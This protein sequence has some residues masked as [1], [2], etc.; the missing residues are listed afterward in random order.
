MIGLVAFLKAAGVEVEADS[1][2]IHL[3]SWTGRHDPLD[4]YYA[5][6][7][8]KW[9][10]DQKHRNFKGAQIIGL[11]AMRSGDWL[12]AGVYRV[13]GCKPLANGRFRYATSLLNGQEGLIGRII[14]HH[15]RSGRQPYIWF[16]P[17]ITTL[18]IAELRREKL[19]IGE[20]PGYNAV[21]LSHSNLKII[22]EQRIASWHGALANIAGV[23]LITDTTTGK[24]YVGKASGGEGIWQRWCSYAK[25]GHGGNEELKKVLKEKGAEHMMHFQYSIL[26]IA[27]TH[28]TEGDILTRESY[29]M[30][31]LKTREFGM[32]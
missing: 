25:N 1:L 20:F 26:E 2:K 9:Q 6:S 17:G 18:S 32:N 10:E 30:S 24:H 19:T 29:W 7:F 23:Y 3:A 15:E 4:V 27:D 5:G 21:V 22:T 13:L 14:V 28:A 11:I 31:A 8:K 12:F 16:K